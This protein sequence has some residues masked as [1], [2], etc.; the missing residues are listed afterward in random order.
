MH[1]IQKLLWLLGMF[2]P[3]LLITAS[4]SFPSSEQAT[5][6]SLNPVKVAYFESRPQK[7]TFGRVMTGFIPAMSAVNGSPFEC[8]S[9]HFQVFQSLKSEVEK[10]KYEHRNQKM[11]HVRGDDSDRCQRLSLL[12]GEV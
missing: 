9:T 2:I 12:R 4:R 11:R 10:D 6:T 1:R 5:N 7:H 8:T 3:I